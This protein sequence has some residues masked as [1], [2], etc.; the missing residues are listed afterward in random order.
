MG[1]GFEH[2]TNA[3]GAGFSMRNVREPM[4]G[5][6]GIAWVGTAVDLRPCGGEAPV[7]TEQVVSTT[8]SLP[9]LERIHVV[10]PCPARWEDMVGD[11]RVRRCED[12]KLN[13]HDLSAMTRDEAEG[14]LAGLAAGRV[15]AQ[16]YRRA[17]GTIL[18]KDCPVGLARLR[19]TA[20]R[21]L[22]RVAALIGLVSVAGIAAGATSRTTWGEKMHLRAC[23]P[24]SIVCE[25][26]APNATPAIP[27][28]LIQLRG[29][30]CVSRAIG[31]QP[32]IVP[33]P[34]PKNRGPTH[35]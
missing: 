2:N 7:P 26:I 24:F 17:D 20:R 35:E 10:S 1:R 4:K 21:A 25:C 16:F 3:T 9:L 31:V 8:I 23:K 15:C 14:V 34:V 28:G 13:V 18:T 33:A 6:G 11:D 19:A 27:V 12:C 30:V 32:P 5:R 29:D 22:V